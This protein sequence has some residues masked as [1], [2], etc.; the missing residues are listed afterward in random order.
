MGGGSRGRVVPRGKEAVWMERS[1]KQAWITGLISRASYK[2]H[3]FQTC[4]KGCWKFGGHIH[5]C[6]R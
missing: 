6:M 5:C 1:D 4:M 3:S 2:K